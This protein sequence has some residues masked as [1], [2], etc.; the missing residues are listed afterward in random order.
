M[1]S[2]ADSMDRVLQ[3]KHLMGQKYFM[4]YRQGTYMRDDKLLIPIFFFLFCYHSLTFS[5]FPFFCRTPAL[6]FTRFPFFISIPHL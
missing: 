3:K 4:S 6:P 5:L 2:V 1:K